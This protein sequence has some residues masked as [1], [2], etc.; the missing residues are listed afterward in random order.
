LHFSIMSHNPFY[1]INVLSQLI[2]V[3]LWEIHIKVILTTLVG[4]GLLTLIIALVHLLTYHNLICFEFLHT[5][6]LLSAL[7]LTLSTANH[8]HS[9]R[10]CLLFPYQSLSYTQTSSN[11]R[12]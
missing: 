3:D 9:I 4:L 8:I 6:L 5:R 7:F 12:R 1:D 10:Q 11:L 2:M